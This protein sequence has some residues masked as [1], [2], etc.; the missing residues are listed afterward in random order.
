[1]RISADKLAARLGK[2]LAPVWFVAGDEPLG[3]EALVQPVEDRLSFLEVME[4]DPAAQPAVSAQQINAPQVYRLSAIIFR[5][6]WLGA[7]FSI[8]RAFFTNCHFV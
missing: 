2:E 3:G 1:M 6:W 4:V 8:E 7:L 5:F